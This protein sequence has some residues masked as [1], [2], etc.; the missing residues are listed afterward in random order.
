M[1][2]KQSTVTEKE[3]CHHVPVLDG[4]RHRVLSES[5]YTEHQYRMLLRKIDRYLLPLMWVAYGVQQVDKTGLSTQAVF[6]IREDTHLVGQQFSWLS[7]IFYLSYM[8]CEF[9]SSYVMQRVSVG[10][11]LSVLM[12]F[13]GIIVLSTGFARNF[14]TLMTLRFLQGAF[15]C[16]ISPSFL[17]IIATWYKTREHTLRAIIWGTA[18]AGFGIITNLCLYAIGNHALKNGGL[19]PWK[20]ISFFLG[21]IT[22]VLSIFSWFLLG[23][24]REVSWVSPEERRIAQARVV[25]NRTGTDAHKRREWKRDQII[26]A[27]IDPSTWFLFFSVVLTS[28]PNGG[29]TSFG[30]LVY[31]SFGFTSLETILY[32]IPRDAASIIWFLLAGWASSRYPNIRFSLMLFAILPGFVGMLTMALLPNDPRYRWIRFGMYFMT[33]S[34]NINGLLLWIFVPSNIAGRTKKSIVSSILFVGY[35]AGNAAGSQFFQEKDAP[36]YVPAIIACAICFALQFCSILA[37]RLYLVYQNHIRDRALMAEGLTR[38]QAKEIGAKLAEED[39]TDR[40]NPYFRYT[41]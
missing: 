1:M 35:C 40:K 41:Y 34:V 6:G 28:L 26:E 39:M 2:S 18:N 38:E 31:K 10:K 25:N 30:N 20:G 17:L 15:E 24:P 4:N 12:F 22:I 29:V 19:A 3:D 36:R 9:P 5:D 14:A 23:T 32:N 27:F 16:T 11:T 33:M 13:W 7:T 21:T 8:V 37:W